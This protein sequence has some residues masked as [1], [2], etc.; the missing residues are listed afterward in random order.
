MAGGQ[1]FAGRAAAAADGV[2]RFA[3]CPAGALHART[4][5]GHSE[6]YSPNA[7]LQKKIEKSLDELAEAAKEA[8]KYL[9]QKTEELK[10][11]RTGPLA[12][13]KAELTKLWP[14]A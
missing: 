6:P 10:A 3:G 7:A 14:R 9:E 1:F 12:G 4:V 13:T 8:A 11:V 5:A 2:A